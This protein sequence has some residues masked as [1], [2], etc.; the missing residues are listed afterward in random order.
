MSLILARERVHRRVLVDAGN[1]RKPRAL[2]DLEVVRVMR[3]R[4]LDRAGT[5]L[6]IRIGVRDD[7]N[8][9]TDQRQDDFLADNRLVAFVIRMH[10]DRFIGE[11]GLR[12]GGRD[13]DAVKISG[14]L[15]GR[16]FEVPIL[17]V[18]ILVFD[19]R[20]RKRCAALRTPVDQTVATVDQTLLI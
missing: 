7:R 12:S 17:A 9:L 19:L 1:D 16:I 2:P 3:R 14:R 6:R 20:V 18:L 15:Y 4:D 5:L 8:F 11:H 13:D 10:R